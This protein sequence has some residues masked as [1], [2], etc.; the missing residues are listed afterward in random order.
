MAK[1]TL[2]DNTD[3]CDGLCHDHV[4]RA[5]LCNTPVQ[6]F[7][8]SPAMMFYGCV[9]KDHLGKFENML[10]VMRQWCFDIGTFLPHGR[11]AY[12]KN[13]CHWIIGSHLLQKD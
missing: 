9:I 12:H 10:D 11:W 5:L 8:M 4:A 13:I 6:D 7:D 2:A 1:H 3:S